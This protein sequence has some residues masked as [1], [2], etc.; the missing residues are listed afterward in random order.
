M[1]TAVGADQLAGVRPSART[2][3]ADVPT[4]WPLAVDGAVELD[5]EANQRWRAKKVIHRRA[6]LRRTN[7]KDCHPAPSS[8]LAASKAALAAAA[9]VL[10]I[11]REISSRLKASKPA[12]PRARINPRT[13]RPSYT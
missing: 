7:E 1:L 4:A 5:F 6:P 3:G 13:S 10:K 11:P 9:A 8:F 12:R 2:D